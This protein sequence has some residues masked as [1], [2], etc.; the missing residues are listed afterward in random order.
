MSLGHFLKRLVPHL[1]AATMLLSC[2][3]KPKALEI[4][5]EVQP[6]YRGALRVT[7][8]SSRNG[9]ARADELGRAYAAAY[10]QP[11]QEIELVVIQ[12]GKSYHI[13]SERLRVNTTGDGIP[14][15][16]IASIE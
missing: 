11:G 3:A 15:E 6:E 16:V 1:L 9:P 8:C 2:G 10:P 13:P 5:V 4:N 12:G 14:V 7:P